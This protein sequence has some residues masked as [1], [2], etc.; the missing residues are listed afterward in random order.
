MA[1]ARSEGQTAR[2]KEL[3]Y[4]LKDYFTR[5]ETPCHYRMCTTESRFEKAELKISSELCKV[6]HEQQVQCVI[7]YF[8]LKLLIFNLRRPYNLYYYM[9]TIGKIYQE[10]VLSFIS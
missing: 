5:P 4:M 9:L 2:A 1:A 6:F 3:R 7:N 8:L 10:P